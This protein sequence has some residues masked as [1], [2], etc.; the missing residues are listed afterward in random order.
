MTLERKSNFLFLVMR[1][2]LKD[3]PILVRICHLWDSARVTDKA[4][5]TC[6]PSGSWPLWSRSLPVIA[7]Q[8]GPRFGILCL[9][10]PCL[11]S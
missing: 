11:A 1:P 3:K 2:Q 9:M 5:H 4:G 6:G 7:V 8:L 10:M